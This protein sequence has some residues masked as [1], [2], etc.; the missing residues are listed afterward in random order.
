MRRELVALEEKGGAG[1]L[2]P[3]LA[4]RVPL[5]LERNILESSQIACCRSC[6]RPPPGCSSSRSASSSSTLS[7][8]FSSTPF[9]GRMARHSK[10]TSQRPTRR[11]PTA[12]LRT[13]GDSAFRVAADPS[14][15]CV[16][17]SADPLTVPVRRAP[18]ESR[19]SPA[20]GWFP[21]RDRD[22]GNR[23]YYRRYSPDG[24]HGTRDHRCLPCSRGAR[25]G[26]VLTLLLIAPLPVMRQ[27]VSGLQRWD[28]WRSRTTWC[29]RSSSA[30]S[31]LH[32]LGLL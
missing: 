21:P 31:S 4:F 30:S 7:A 8:R 15:A 22:R 5:R 16:R 17:L 10:L 11:M 28:A 9:P 32:G 12:T 24:N 1:R 25:V 26:Y 27:A 2:A 6:W 23:R 29:N 19:H 14:T 13:R 3:L 20:R 18:V